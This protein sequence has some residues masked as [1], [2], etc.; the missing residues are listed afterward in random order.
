MEQ[1]NLITSQTKTEIAIDFIREHEPEDGYYVGF[2]GGKDSQVLYHLVSDSGV[3]FQAYYAATGIDPPELLRFVRQNYPDVK[4]I[5]PELNFFRGIKEKCPPTKKIRWCCDK[6]K[7]I[8]LKR[9]PLRHRLMGLRAEESAGRR[10]RG[11][12]SKMGKQIIYSPIFTWLEWEVWEYIDSRKLPYCSLYDEGFSRLGCVVC[13]F[14]TGRKILDV[15]RKR[16]PKHYHAFEI[17]MRKFW[18]TKAKHQCRDGS[19]QTFD[20]FLTNWYRGK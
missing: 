2:S 7:H 11:Q 14:L 19:P 9:V 18:D 8:N 5:R 10:K 16:W 15:H 17:A 6:L 20:E 3:K 1:L 13:P 4:W 12:I